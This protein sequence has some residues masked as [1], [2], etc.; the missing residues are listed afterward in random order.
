MIQYRVNIQLHTIITCRKEPHMPG[1][2]S[3][4]LK[5]LTTTLLDCGPFGSDR[6]LVKVFVDERIAPWKNQVSEADN[7]K[8]RV[9]F[10]V[11]DFL[12]RKNRAGQSVLVLF[13]QAVYD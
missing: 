12:N 2:P 5:R 3:A 7:K 8:D 13:L 1:L 9:D 4:L 10:F 11:S 6:A